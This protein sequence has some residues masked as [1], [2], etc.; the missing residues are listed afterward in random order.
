MWNTV[1]HME[2]AT[3]QSEKD[4]NYDQNLAK[5]RAFLATQFQSIPAYGSAE[6]WR[7]IEESQ[8]MLALPLEVLVKCV[9]VALKKEDYTSKQK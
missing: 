8:L 4:S 2:Q 3:F 5:R 1:G 9:H 7:R 6:F